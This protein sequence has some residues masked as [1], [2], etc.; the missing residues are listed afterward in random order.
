MIKQQIEE[1]IK[2][3]MLGGD[4]QLVSALRNLKSAILYAEVAAGKKD[5]GLPEAEVIT[6]LQKEAKKRQES[7]EM[8][9]KGG[10]PDKAVAEEYEKTVIDGYLPEAM[11]EEEVDKLID[12]AVAN[13]GELSRQTMG[14]VIGFVKTKAGGS[15]DGG[16]VA[17]LVQKRL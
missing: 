9:K 15:V 3:A 10:A 8:Y 12:E 14:Q 17:K 13:V 1:D 11:S 2:K 4:K 6:L 7:A 16:T 5:E